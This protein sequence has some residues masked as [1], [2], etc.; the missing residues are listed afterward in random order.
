[1]AVAIKVPIK[2]KLESV[3]TG[4]P[5]TREPDDLVIKVDVDKKRAK[6]T[7]HAELTER[8]QTCKGLIFEP[9]EACEVH[10]DNP[11]VFGITTQVLT[12]GRNPRLPLAN[13]NKPDE[14]PYWFKAG[15]GISADVVDLEADYLL[16]MSRPSPLGD[17]RIVV[18]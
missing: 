1:M 2:Q 6:A 4:T 8:T 15:T 14:T 16:M 9:T 3:M 18:P 7:I 17:P 12:K 5:C 11:N 10:F 13:P